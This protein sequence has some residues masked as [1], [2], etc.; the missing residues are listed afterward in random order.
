[1]LAHVFDAAKRILS[2]SPSYQGDSEVTDQNIPRSAQADAEDNAMV[3]TRRGTGTAPSVDST[4]ASSVRQTRGKRHLEIEIQQTPTASKRRRKGV[5]KEDPATGEEDEQAQ[6]NVEAHADT[7]QDEDPDFVTKAMPHRTKNKKTYDSTEFRTP[8]ARRSSPKILIPTKDSTDEA[9]ESETP[10]S[11]VDIF[12]TPAQQSFTLPAE[13]DEREGSLTPRPTAKAAKTTPASGKG[14]GKRGRPRKN[15]VPTTVE[16]TPVKPNIP[17]ETPDEILD[18]IPSSTWNSEQAPLSP[19]DHNDDSE[20]SV[21]S[22]K[23]NGNPAI[24]DENN[25][26]EEL[27]EQD[28]ASMKTDATGEPRKDQVENLA[29]L[30]V[31]YEDSAPDTAAGP[32]RRHKRFDSE[33]PDDVLET[34]MHAA[35]EQEAKADDDNYASDSDDAPEMITTSAAVSKAKAAAAEASHARQAQQAKEE[36]RRQERADRITQEQAEK[37]ER[38]EKRQRKLIKSQAKLERQQQR[39]ASSPPQAPTDLNM[40]DLPDLLPESILEA[41]GDRRPP[42]PPFVRGG[43]T[44][45]E[46]RQEKMNRHI[47]FLDRSEKPIKDLKKGK[48]NVSV[49]SQRN[50]LLAPKV[51]RNTKSIREHWLKGREADRKGSGKNG[52]SFKKMERRATPK[53][54]LRG[55]DDD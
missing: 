15:P 55:G 37:R 49:L 48:V 5:S 20:A 25:S 8:I 34:T 14:S 22:N 50:E 13:E 6:S 19:A 35:P 32:Q 27:Q 33:E 41:A 29:S 52:R 3:T 54:F 7:E 47:K 2:R 42:T 21:I 12:Y 9:H 11:Q 17:D 1:M 4:P 46:V 10:S 31:A 38:E 18:E 40:R 53:G 36:K 26:S 24:L 28:V 39:Q 45:G 43:K 16:D 23:V 51:N 44:K 30:S